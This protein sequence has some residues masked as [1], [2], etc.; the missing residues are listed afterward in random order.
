MEAVGNLLW[1]Q[2]SPQ[3][4]D[5]T[6]CYY[7]V[8]LPTQIIHQET[9]WELCRSLHRVALAGVAG[10]EMTSAKEDRREPQKPASSQ[11]W[12]SREVRRPPGTLAAWMRERLRANAL[13][14]SSRRRD[15]CRCG[16][17]SRGLLSGWKFA[18]GIQR[19]LE[20]KSRSAACRRALV[21]ATPRRRSG[22]IN[23][24]ACRTSAPAPM[25]ARARVGG[26]SFRR[27]WRQL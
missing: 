15:T 13:T 12:V 4:T 21:S 26:G 6:S 24:P 22:S 3:Q 19:L 20:R 18:E 1:R 27:P 25:C 5:K 7:R 17:A 10:G 14:R 2:A 8:C 23:A 16:P 11:K 9:S